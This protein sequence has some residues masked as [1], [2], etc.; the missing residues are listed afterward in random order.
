MY[1]PPKIKGS[2]SINLDDMLEIRLLRQERKLSRLRDRLFQL[3]FP[4]KQKSKIE[5]LASEIAAIDWVLKVLDSQ[6]DFK[7]DLKKSLSET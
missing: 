5:E 6:E 1:K 4:V 7:I 3:K 2:G